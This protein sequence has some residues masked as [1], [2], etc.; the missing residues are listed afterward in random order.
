MLALLPAT[1]GRAATTHLLL[2]VIVNGNASGLV[3][4]FDRD[5]DGRL[6][7]AAA[8]LRALRV[9]VPDEEAASIALDRLSGVSYRYDDA[10]QQLQLSIAPDAL[11]VQRLSG[12][13]PSDGPAV[14]DA[15]P[16]TGA[17]VNY[18]VDVAL[19]SAGSPM[20]FR[21]GILDIDMLAYHHRTSLHQTGIA[22]Y[23]G[24]AA[25]A[26]RFE[27]TVARLIG[28][29]RLVARMGDAISG[30][31]A[32]TRPIRFAGLQLQRDFSLRPDLVTLPLPRIGGSAAV[33]SS[34]DVYVNGVR[35]YSNGTVQG[36]FQIED[37]PMVTGGGTA[38]IVLRDV[39]GREVETTTRFFTSSRM[40]RAGLSEYSVETGF[41]RRGFGTASFDYATEPFLAASGRIGLTQG[42]TAEGHLELSRDVVL[43]GGGFTARTGNIGVLSAALAAS[44][45]AH[46]R[47]L[48]ASIGYDMAIGPVRLAIESRRTVGDYTDLAADGG[49]GIDATVRAQ[50]QPPRALDRATLG[51]QLGRGGGNLSLNY[52][53]EVRASTDR[54][55][56]ASLF[57]ART[58]GRLSLNTSGFRDFAHSGNYGLFASVSLALGD[59][60]TASATISSD[61]SGATIASEI[62]QSL[63]T[64][65]DSVGGRVIA[66]RGRQTGVSAAID[67]QGANAT[68]HGFFGQRGSQ[69]QANLRAESAIIVD[70]GV[71]AA[72]GGQAGYAIV[73]TGTP[74]AAI[75][76]SNRPLGKAGRRGRMLVAQIRP[77]ERN[78][79]SVDP[80][81]L[82]LDAAIPQPAQWFRPVGPGVVRVK[83]QV[84]MNASSALLHLIDET[85]ANLPMGTPVSVN[86]GAPVILGF[87]GL[88]LAENLVVSNQVAI[89]VGS[90]SCDV[91]FTFAQRAVGLQM[92]GPLTCPRA[93]QFASTASRN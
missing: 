88:V 87:D 12:A 78:L 43:F 25:R 73:E 41:A 48:L 53:R 79:V 44:R 90:H 26:V 38:R 32:W 11:S 86:G 60:R 67:Y 91:R 72:R 3:V 51:L 18:G 93:P 71:Y 39:T 5:E 77:Y 65:T 16:G 75:S 20:A 2:E 29:D 15:V 83:F 89:D 8:D 35:N 28:R 46:D 42:L 55:Q 10:R 1:P 61:A 74:G 23:D 4:E 64:R 40:L 14:V 54:F 49:T 76:V 70:H 9:A 36:R 82:P 31:L 47:G 57:Y 45:S 59:R 85:G 50:L 66:F 27:T 84:D 68:L 62:A 81:S 69:R 56:T 17:V 13:P 24:N 33:P 58:I 63:D 92:I 37:L 80:A 52:A 22:I 34:L 19:G 21:Q 6:S 7:A 30:G